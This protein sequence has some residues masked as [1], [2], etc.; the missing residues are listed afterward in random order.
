MQNGIIKIWVCK[1]CEKEFLDRQVF[2]TKCNG[3]EF[4]VKYGGIVSNEG[5]LAKMIDTYKDDGF[6]KPLK[7]K[8][9]P[10]PEKQKP[11]EKADTKKRTR[12]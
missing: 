2:C 1:N 3:A 8:I 9:Q 7:A 10:K 6:D 11:P 4:Y 12:I 5:D